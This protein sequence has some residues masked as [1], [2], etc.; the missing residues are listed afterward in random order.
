MNLDPVVGFSVTQAT[1]ALDQIPQVGRFS[2]SWRDP[3][4][5]FQPMRPLNNER[6]IKINCKDYVLLV[7]GLGIEHIDRTISGGHLFTI[8][9]LKC[10]E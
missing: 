2:E 3:P 9:L 8:A 6:G 7:R 5:G 1:L 4:N 10:S